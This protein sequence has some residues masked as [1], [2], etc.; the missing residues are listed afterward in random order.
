MIVAILQARYNSSRLPGKVLLP[1]GEKPMLLQQILRVQRCQKIDHLVV[2][3]STLPT[4]DEIAQLCLENQIACFRGEL[5]DVLDRYYQAAVQYQATHVVRLTGDCPLS[6]PEVI[7]QVVQQHLQ[8]QNDYTSNTLQPS[9]PDGLDVEVLR[10]SAL[11]CAWQNA[12]RTTEREHVTY[13]TYQRPEQFKL[14]CLQYRQDLS[15]WRLTVDEV[16]DYHVVSRIFQQLYT[17]KP[18]F[19]FEDIVT[20]IIQQP[21][22]IAENAHYIRNEGLQKSLIEDREIPHVT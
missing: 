18:T 1:F 12:T 20:H 21:E 16:A 22:L 13:Y 6:S 2:A 14:G 17:K 19:S 10:M 5:D 4:D 15:S 7:D 11:S 8:Q 3:T 9:F